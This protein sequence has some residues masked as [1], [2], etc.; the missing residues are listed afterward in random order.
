[1]KKAY[2]ELFKE[3]YST[4]NAEIRQRIRSAVAKKLGIRFASLFFEDDGVLVYDGSGRVAGKIS[5]EEFARLL[6]EAG[7]VYGVME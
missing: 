2:I 1:M 6:N 7:I 5:Y 3:M 4:G